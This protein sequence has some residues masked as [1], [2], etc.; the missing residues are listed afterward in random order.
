M[1]QQVPSA[2]TL[3]WAEKGAPA[4]SGRHATKS[5]AAIVSASN[6][7]AE[8]PSQSAMSRPPW[9]ST[10]VLAAFMSSG[11]MIGAGSGGKVAKAGRRRLPAAVSRRRF[12]VSRMRARW[13]TADPEKVKACTMPSPSNQWP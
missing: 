4:R 12:G 8:P 7:S 11:A 1:F 13:L 10:E 3:G 6:S 5:P 9:A 2:S